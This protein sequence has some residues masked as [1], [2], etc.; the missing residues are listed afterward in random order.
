M[1]LNGSLSLLKI[2]DS[3]M[4]RSI[5]IAIYIISILVGLFILLFT[6]QLRLSILVNLFTVGHGYRESL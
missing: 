5:P 3:S 2:G 1:K 6:H 4:F